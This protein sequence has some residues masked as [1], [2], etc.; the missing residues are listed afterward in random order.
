MKTRWIIVLLAVLLVCTLLGVWMSRRGQTVRV[1]EAKH[2]EALARVG[3]ATSG[4]P[5]DAV[6]A[7]IRTEMPGWKIVVF[8]DEGAYRAW[9]ARASTTV[10]DTVVVFVKNGDVEWLSFGPGKWTSDAGSA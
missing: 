1:M 10:V 2:I 3:I 9:N 8:Y 6:L 7:A 5:V 4:Q